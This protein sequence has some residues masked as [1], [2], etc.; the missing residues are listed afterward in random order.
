MN[1]LQQP[2][3]PNPTLLTPVDPEIQKYLLTLT[4]GTDHP[5]L[6]EMEALARFG[7]FGCCESIRGVPP[8]FSQRNKGFPNLAKRLSDQ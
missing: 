5:V 7:V 2:N 1:D 8:Y 6:S 4:K 3:T